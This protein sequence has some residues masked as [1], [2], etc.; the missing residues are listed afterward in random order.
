MIDFRY[1][2]N[3]DLD[4][5]TY[6]LIK[7]YG[8]EPWKDQW[9]SFEIARTY[10]KEFIDNPAFK[11][12]V[13]LNN[14]KIVGVCFGHRKTWWQGPEFYIDEYFIDSDN[15]RNG[16]GSQLIEYLKNDLL[17]EQ[18]NCMVLLTQKGYPSEQFYIKQGFKESPSTIFMYKTSK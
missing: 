2:E 5:I 18:I 7:V 12:L 16:I 15:Q 4:E 17:K 10:L 11:G 13:A 3:S 6:L 9:P 1:F 14:N 8:Q